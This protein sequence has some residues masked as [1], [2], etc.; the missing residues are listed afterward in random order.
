M[1]SRGSVIR[2]EG[3]RCEKVLINGIHLLLC[4]LRNGYSVGRWDVWKRGRGRLCD[5]W[6]VRVLCVG[7]RHGGRCSARVLS[8]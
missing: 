4:Q 1:R 3:D 5:I 6:E 2:G 8:L 7:V